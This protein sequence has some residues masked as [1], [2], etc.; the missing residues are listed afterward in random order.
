VDQATIGQDS[1]AID[2][3][4]RQDAIRRPAIAA[5]ICILALATFFQ[6]PGHTWLQQDSQ[7]YTPILEHQRDPTV[8]AND[9]L[10]RHPHVA[11]T[12][13]D[14]AARFLR[15]LTGAGFK[16]VL[17]FQQIVTRA[18]GIWGLYLMAVALGLS[19]LPALT[20]AA[21]CSLGAAITGPAVLTFE[22]EPTP[23]AFAAPLLI[24]AAGLAAQ[25]R[26]VWSGVAAACAF[27]Y[28]APTTWPFLLIFTALVCWRRE[29]RALLPL[30]AA[31]AI[32]AWAAAGQTEQ[33]FFARLDP[34]LEQLQ[35]MRASYVW[36]SMWRPAVIAHWLIL[37]GLA[38]FLAVRLRHKIPPELMAFAAGLP[39]LGLVSIPASWLL[40]E[41]MKWALIPQV[42]PARAL[43]FVTLFA[44]FLAAC[45]AFKSKWPVSALWFAIAF[46]P[47]LQAV[48]T[49]PWSLR[50]TALLAAL[51][52]LAA[53]PRLAP[54]AAAAAFFAIPWAG[55][56]FNY[57]QLHNPE[58]AKLSA[59]ART[60]TPRD[61]VFLFPDAG[62]AL[63]PGIF[64]SE[65]LRAVYADWKGGGQA[66][67]V[68]PL[69]VDWWFRWQQT[70]EHGFRPEDLPKY[71][72]LGIRYVVLT[73]KNRLPE[74]AVFEDADYV[75][76]EL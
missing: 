75:V 45:A 49:D 74:P 25:R 42:Q 11:F 2:S 64:R 69:A 71:S 24:L 34:L 5:A 18:L 68:K 57:P 27:L 15:G 61:A 72:G 33:T 29:W 60:S 40:L 12:L 65:A 35:R 41:G 20:V 67:Y 54:V 36:I 8:L 14:E 58:L 19:A 23:R 47:P 44:Q 43:L 16:G 37:A 48:V 76:Y 46:L 6:F 30:A 50:R 62:H 21:I 32:L 31:G 70:M 10:T 59:W 13:Y 28:H 55:G 39:L 63:Y 56:V 53:A 26:F 38:A 51:A 73:R 7:I 17:Q 52:L 1:R 9:I 4:A 66:N 22:Y 3:A